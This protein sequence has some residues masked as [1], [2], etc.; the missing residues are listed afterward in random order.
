[1]DMGGLR[2]NPGR[3]ARDQVV[4]MAALAAQRG[5]LAVLAGAM[6]QQAAHGALH[7]LSNRSLWNRQQK[8]ES[9]TSLMPRHRRCHPGCM[10]VHLPCRSRTWLGTRSGR[11]LCCCTCPCSASSS[12]ASRTSCRGTVHPGS[13]RSTGTV[14]GNRRCRPQCMVLSCTPHSNLAAGLVDLVGEAVGNGQCSLA[15]GRSLYNRVREG[16][17]LLR[18]RR[19]PHRRRLR[20]R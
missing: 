1:M 14:E 4:S 20:R 12:T 7:N 2:N 10:M 8:I 9:L 6:A 5:A 18:H 3:A 16:R 15:A 13:S 19:R 17:S 11:L